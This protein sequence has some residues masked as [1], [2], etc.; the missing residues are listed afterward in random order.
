MDE[1]VD[2]PRFRLDHTMSRLL[3][4]N[5]AQLDPRLWDV[6]CLGKLARQK[7]RKVRLAMPILAT[8]MG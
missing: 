4:Q 7:F 8:L 6:Y 5:G 3:R 1:Q 2:E